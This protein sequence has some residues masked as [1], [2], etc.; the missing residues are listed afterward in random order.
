MIYSVE[1]SD[2]ADADLR[3]IFYYR[4]HR[5]GDRQSLADNFN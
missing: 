4:G 5:P 1:I 3:G 2:Q